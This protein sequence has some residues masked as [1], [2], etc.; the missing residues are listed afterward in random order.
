MQIRTRTRTRDVAEAVIELLGEVVEAE[1][2]IAE[3]VK[4]WIPHAL[5]AIVESVIKI[6][7]S[8]DGT[9]VNDAMRAGTVIIEAEEIVVDDQAETVLD[10]VRG[11][12]DAEVTAH[13]VGAGREETVIVHLVGNEYVQLFRRPALPQETPS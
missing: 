9:V 7:S 13:E 12:I 1:V 6:Q 2:A 10:L 3:T 4:T 11:S 5:D 8:R